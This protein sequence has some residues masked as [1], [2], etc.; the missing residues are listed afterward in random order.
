M[1]NSK[2]SLSVTLLH[3]VCD[4]TE[5]LTHACTKDTHELKS[6]REGGL[7]CSRNAPRTVDYWMGKLG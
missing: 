2:E 5:E 4:A 7:V 6:E 1:V 3:L